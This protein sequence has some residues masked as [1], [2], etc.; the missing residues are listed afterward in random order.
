MGLLDE[1]RFLTLMEFNLIFYFMGIVF[2][3]IFKTAFPS[4]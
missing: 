4:S 3:V 2:G 1:Q